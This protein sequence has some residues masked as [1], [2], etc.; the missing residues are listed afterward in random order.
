MEVLSFLHSSWPPYVF[1][2]A[3]G[4]LSLLLWI[5]LSVAILAAGGWTLYVPLISALSE[6]F[7]GETAALC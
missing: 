4:L 6:G 2:T 1:S 7:L 5:K 3:C